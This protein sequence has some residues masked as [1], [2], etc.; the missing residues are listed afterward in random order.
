MASTE[1]CPTWLNQALAF[2]GD[3]VTKSLI[4]LRKVR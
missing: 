4:L 3:Y 2:A 1:V